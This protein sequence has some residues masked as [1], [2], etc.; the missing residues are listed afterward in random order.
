MSKVGR[1]KRLVFEAAAMEARIHIRWLF[2][3]LHCY[4]VL[5]CPEFYIALKLSADH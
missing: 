5:R 3:V 1:R 4:S 2:H